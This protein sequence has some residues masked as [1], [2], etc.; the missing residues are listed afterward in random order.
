[1][2]IIGLF[3]QD[4]V[5]C[6]S[7]NQLAQIVHYQ[8]RAMAPKFLCVPFARDAD[9]KAKVPGRPSHH[10]RDGILYYNR[11]CRLDPEQLCRSQE[12]IRGGFSGQVLGMD[13]V[14]IDLHVE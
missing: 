4:S 6:G 8:T 11:A 14:A 7:V 2:S 9:H 1:L 3:L 13:H 10:S 5:E 12:R